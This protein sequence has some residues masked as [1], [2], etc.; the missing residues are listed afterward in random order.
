M[1]RISLS[2]D[3]IQKRIS[4]MPEDVKDQV[5]NESISDVFFSGG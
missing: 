4:D 1:R 2:N 5:M 3:S